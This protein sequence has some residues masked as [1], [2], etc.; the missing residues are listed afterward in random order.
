M[1][2]QSKKLHSHVQLI[3]HKYTK[4]AAVL[5]FVNGKTKLGRHHN[6]AV[7]FNY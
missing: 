7:K 6:N 2:E 1:T 4:Q 5:S 3:S